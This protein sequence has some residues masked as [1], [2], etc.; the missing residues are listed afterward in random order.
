[1]ALPKISR[2]VCILWITLVCPLYTLMTLGLLL[3][4]LARLI[5]RPG[6]FHQAPLIAGTFWFGILVGL[7]AYLGRGVA[8]RDP[9]ALKM[10]RI[11]LGFGVVWFG[12]WFLLCAYDLFHS[13]NAKSLFLPLLKD[14][15][16]VAINCLC[17]A[18]L[19]T[20][21]SEPVSR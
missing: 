9:G 12:I 19:A 5:H 11:P 16:T 20:I 7:M 18:R 21:P 10:A 2:F 4:V 8:T 15:A 17:W 14:V 3:G 13:P 6:M 1:M